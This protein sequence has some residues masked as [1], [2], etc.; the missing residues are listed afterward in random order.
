MTSD[1]AIE[2]C[3]HQENHRGVMLCGRLGKHPASVCNAPC[4]EVLQDEDSAFVDLKIDSA[5]G[6]E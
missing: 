1:V 3:Q 5:E 6:W 2:P 4:N